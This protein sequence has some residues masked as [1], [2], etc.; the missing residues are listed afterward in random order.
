MYLLQKPPKAGAAATK[1]KPGM[2]IAHDALGVY[3]PPL[4]T[5]L[6]KN[7]PVTELRSGNFQKLQKFQHIQEV[8]KDYAKKDLSRKKVLIDT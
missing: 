6:K 3:T 8:A 5:L 4:K 2:V 1:L 7:K